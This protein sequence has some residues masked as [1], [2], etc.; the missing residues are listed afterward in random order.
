MCSLDLCRGNSVLEL[1]LAAAEGLEAGLQNGGDS[2]WAT[3]SQSASDA[4]LLDKISRLSQCV[5][6]SLG[7]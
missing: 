3:C 7:P 1:V 2:K 5:F 4:R 6:Q